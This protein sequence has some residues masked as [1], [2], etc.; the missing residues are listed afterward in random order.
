MESS[1]PSDAPGM[2]GPSSGAGGRRHGGAAR[3]P[4]SARGAVSAASRSRPYLDEQVMPRMGD[5]Q[6]EVAEEPLAVEGD[7]VLEEVDGQF[8]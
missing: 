4:S 1:P 6:G 2:A 3:T 8:P 5:V 7:P